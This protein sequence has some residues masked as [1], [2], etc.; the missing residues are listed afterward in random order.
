[1]CALALGGAKYSGLL[2]FWKLAV[3]SKKAAG[4]AQKAAGFAQKAPGFG[5]KAALFTQTITV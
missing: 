5:Q 1:M 4:F 3:F 2:N